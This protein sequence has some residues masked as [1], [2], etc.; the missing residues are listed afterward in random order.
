MNTN[1]KTYKNYYA[2]AIEGSYYIKKGTFCKIIHNKDV[3]KIRKE[4]KY[5]FPYTANMH[6]EDDLLNCVV[7][8]ETVTKT[9]SIL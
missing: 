3:E 1:T 2:V 4:G 6:F 5:R 7:V 9:Y 8:E